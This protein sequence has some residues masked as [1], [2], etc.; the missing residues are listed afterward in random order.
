MRMSAENASNGMGCTS[1]ADQTR[2]AAVFL[3]L[4]HSRW[5]EKTLFNS[6]L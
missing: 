5:G 6:E 2:Q 1:E 3:R 4:R